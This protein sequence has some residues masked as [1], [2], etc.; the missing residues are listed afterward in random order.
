MP[1]IE[2]EDLATI[3][4]REGR[5]DVG[6]TMR[7]ARSMVSGLAPRTPPAWCTAT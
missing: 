6:R 3:L 4:K 2:G 7:I 1:Y 5:L